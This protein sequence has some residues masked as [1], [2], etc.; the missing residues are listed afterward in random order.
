[1][2]Y[3]TQISCNETADDTDW[4][5][6]KELMMYVGREHVMGVAVGNEVELL[7]TQKGVSKKCIEDMFTGGWLSLYKKGFFLKVLLLEG[8]ASSE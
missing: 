7:H 3:G 5:F 2:L 8:D 4:L 6:V 1:M